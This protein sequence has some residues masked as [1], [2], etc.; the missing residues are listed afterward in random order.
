M[1]NLFYYNALFSLNVVLDALVFLS[2]GRVILISLY[3]EKINIF[4]FIKVAGFFLVLLVITLSA[5]N[6]FYSYERATHGFVA[7]FISAGLTLIFFGLMILISALKSLN[8][9]SLYSAGF[10][11]ILIN[12]SKKEV[13]FS[14]LLIL[15]SVVMFLMAH[16]W[17]II[18]QRF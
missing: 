10:R 3:E 18:I 15:L 12:E 2:V 5:N 8:T 14:L 9:S 13:A 16:F 7:L 17:V 1:M 4:T 11:K 6:I